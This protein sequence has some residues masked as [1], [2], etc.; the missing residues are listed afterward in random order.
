[1]AIPPADRPERCLARRLEALGTRLGEREA[2]HR[3]GLH[4]ARARAEKLRTEVETALDRFHRAVAE[5]GAPH[6][7]VTLSEIQV[8][9]K[10][11]RAVEFNLRRG[12]IKSVVTIK[13]QGKT[14]LVGPFRIGKTERPCASFAFDADRELD[15]ALG[16]FL[17]RFLEE[18]STP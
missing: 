7:R 14:T 2:A 9:D 15:D 8:D 18:A 3:R 5:A 16:D 6:L 1:M 12:S 11:L 13:A 17:E 4:E 10:H